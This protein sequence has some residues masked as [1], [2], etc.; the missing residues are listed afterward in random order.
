[1]QK[2]T[3]SRGFLAAERSK[4]AHMY[5]QAFGPKLARVIGPE[6]R[7]LAFF[8]K[9]MNPEFALAA[10]GPLGELVGLAGFKIANGSLTSGGF[11]DLARIYG[12]LAACW[13][14]PF[15][16]MLERDPKPD[17]LLMDGILSPTRRGGR[18]LVRNFVN[19]DQ[20]RGHRAGLCHRAAGCD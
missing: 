18:G 9:H 16:A 14:V 11:R 8:A 4:V 3:I 2:T 15:L 6:D 17:V 7:A 12:F 13:R 5:W 1:M 20:D 10:R 19:G